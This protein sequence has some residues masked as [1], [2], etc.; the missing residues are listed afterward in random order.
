[1]GHAKAAFCIDHTQE[2]LIQAS[3]KVGDLVF[4]SMIKTNLQYLR[5]VGVEN[6][7]PQLATH[8]VFF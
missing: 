3:L 8:Y 6:S 5:V 2:A 4:G 7:R 1:M